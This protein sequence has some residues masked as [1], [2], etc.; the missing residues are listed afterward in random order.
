MNCIGC[1][2]EDINSLKGGCL[3]T[4][5]D[6]CP[7]LEGDSMTYEDNEADNLIDEYEFNNYF[8]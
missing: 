6:I 5:K 2:F 8:N 3:K 7:E 1:H 4:D